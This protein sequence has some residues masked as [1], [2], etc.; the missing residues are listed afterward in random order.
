MDQ[1]QGWCEVISGR[2]EED[3]MAGHEPTGARPW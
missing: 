2:R 3:R 1:T